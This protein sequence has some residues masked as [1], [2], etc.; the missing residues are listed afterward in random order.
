MCVCL[1]ACVCMC[2]FGGISL[3]PNML[4]TWV[5][6]PPQKGAYFRTQEKQQREGSRKMTKM[7]YKNIQIHQSSNKESNEVKTGENIGG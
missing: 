1:C 7:R 4:F 6:A 5:G 3:G 2:V